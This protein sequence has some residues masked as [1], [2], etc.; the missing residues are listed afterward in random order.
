MLHI[1]LQLMKH[2]IITAN[3]IQHNLVIGNQQ[4]AFSKRVLWYP[5]ETVRPDT[6]R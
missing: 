5:R 6:D 2:Y 4:S 3:T 1:P